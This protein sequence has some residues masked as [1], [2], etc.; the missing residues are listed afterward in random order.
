MGGRTYLPPV[1]SVVSSCIIVVEKF[2][3]GS[4]VA[5]QMG[6][7]KSEHCRGIK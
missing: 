5:I 4:E 3:E 1:A 6:I 7:F 2:W